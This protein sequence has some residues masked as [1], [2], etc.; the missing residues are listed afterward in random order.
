MPHL[1]ALAEVNFRRVPGLSPDANLTQAGF[2]FPDGRFEL[3]GSSG[4]SPRALLFFINCLDV[5]P[6]TPWPR[7]VA[8]S[9]DR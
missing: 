4:L 1:T 3:R 6:I 5:E 8:H 7:L 2:D 9:A